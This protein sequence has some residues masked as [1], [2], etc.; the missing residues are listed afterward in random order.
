[1]RDQIP[2][3][4]TVMQV[5]AHFKL[6]VSL[7]ILFFLTIFHYA[8]NLGHRDYQKAGPVFKEFVV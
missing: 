8:Q 2:V 1:M 7:G 6:H 4:K 3:P 5:G